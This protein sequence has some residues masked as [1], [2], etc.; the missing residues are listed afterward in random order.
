MS[1]GR[2]FFKDPNDT[3]DYEISWA[4][5]LRTSEAI[6][7]STWTVPD[8][9]TEESESNTTTTATIWLSGGTR[10]TDYRVTNHITTNQGRVKDCTLVIEVRDQ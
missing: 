10:T 1:A 2:N 3:L 4:S 9:I 8:G 7:T 5:W 6:D